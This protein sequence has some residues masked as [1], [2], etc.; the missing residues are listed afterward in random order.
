MGGHDGDS[1]AV[2]P[3]YFSSM[4][5]SVFSLLLDCFFFGV[6]SSLLF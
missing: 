5:P 4:Y 1:T 2:G 3:G 6:F